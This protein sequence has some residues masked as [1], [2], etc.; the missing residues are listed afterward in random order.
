MRPSRLSPLSPSSL[1]ERVRS[2][3]ANARADGWFGFIFWG[4]AYLSMRRGRD[5]RWGTTRRALETA[6]NYALIAF[7]AYTLV[8]GTY[9]RRPR[10]GSISADVVQVSVKSI[11]VDS[12]GGRVFS[13]ASNGF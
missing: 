8:A 7:G 11:I 10:C 3:F 13:C 1:P 6:L 4:M 5:A 12:K 2:L 9:V